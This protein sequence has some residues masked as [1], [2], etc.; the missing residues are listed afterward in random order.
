ML[1]ERRRNRELQA[2]QDAAWQNSDAKPNQ[3]PKQS[4]TQTIKYGIMRGMKK[5]ARR[6]LIFAAA[7]AGGLAAPLRSALTRQTILF[8]PPRATCLASHTSGCWQAEMTMEV[9]R[10]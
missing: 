2:K 3:I 10:G 1:E 7:I 9:K 4:N 8:Y 5:N 6:A